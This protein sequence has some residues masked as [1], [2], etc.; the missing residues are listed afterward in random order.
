MAGVADTLGVDAGWEGQLMHRAGFTERAPTVLAD[1]LECR[2][3]TQKSR[4]GSGLGR[5]TRGENKH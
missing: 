3:R 4:R 5:S 2:K 1:I